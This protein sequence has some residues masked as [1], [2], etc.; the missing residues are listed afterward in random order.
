ML[1]AVGVDRYAK[2]T[3]TPP[4]TYVVYLASPS[5][6]RTWFGGPVAE[7]G[8]Y[9]LQLSRDSAAPVLDTSGGYGVAY[10]SV[11]C[12]ATRFG[13]DRMLDFYGR[14]VRQ[15]GPLDQASQ[16]AFGQPWDRVN[17]DCA[18][19]VRQKAAG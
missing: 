18:G 3:T 1:V 13:E 5:E 12:L 9:A 10:L 11:T 15:N 4:T 19:F 8:G 6:W 14:V 17:A 2:L 7:P 16:L